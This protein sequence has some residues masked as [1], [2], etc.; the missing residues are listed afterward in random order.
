[1]VS[2]VMVVVSSSGG[3]WLLATGVQS[4]DVMV[5]GVQGVY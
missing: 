5:V 4:A 2:P 1:M 3:Y